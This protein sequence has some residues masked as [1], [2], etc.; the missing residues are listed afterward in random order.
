MPETK[1]YTGSCH[2]GKVR[3]DVSLELGQVMQCNCSLCSRAGYLMTFVPGQQFKLESGEDN[4][5]DY[6]FNTHNIHHTFC[7]TCGV[8]SFARGKDRQGNAMVMINVR[9]L[10][11]VD[12]NTLS[13]K[14]VDG[15]SI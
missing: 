7:K 13:I 10:Q 1:H 11:D 9:C 14:Q 15:K 12:P 8:R 5:I 4:L 6:Q 3:Y 2:C